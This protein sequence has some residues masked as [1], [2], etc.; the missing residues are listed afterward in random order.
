MVASATQKACSSIHVCFVVN[1]TF[2]THNTA[3]DNT[4]GFWN[5]RDQRVELQY[6]SAIK[7]SLTLDW[8]FS[9]LINQWRDSTLNL[10]K[11][12]VFCQVEEWGG[13]GECL[14]L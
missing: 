12:Y 5:I 2:E 6:S 10:P 13:V 14:R 3:A 8:W 4:S 11:A 1:R 7:V 9:F